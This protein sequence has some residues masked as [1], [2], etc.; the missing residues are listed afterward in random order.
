[1]PDPTEQ[2]VKRLANLCGQVQTHP[3]IPAAA[4]EALAEIP[5]VLMELTRRVQ[6]IEGRGGDHAEET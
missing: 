5:A 1:M 3:M 6:R 4:R 2:R